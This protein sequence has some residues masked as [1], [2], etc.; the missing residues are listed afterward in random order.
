VKVNAGEKGS[1]E[2]E[3]REVGDIV[4]RKSRGW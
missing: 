3:D 4:N 2:D 1:S